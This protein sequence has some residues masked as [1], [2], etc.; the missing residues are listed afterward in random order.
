LDAP[1][2]VRGMRRSGPGTARLLGGLSR[3]FFEYLDP[4]RDGRLR[5]RPRPWPG[6]D[7]HHQRRVPRPPPQTRADSSSPTPRKPSSSCAVVVPSPA[8]SGPRSP[9]RPPP[10]Q[11]S[12]RLGRQRPYTGHSSSSGS[13]YRIFER[14][15]APPLFADVDQRPSKAGRADVDWFHLSL[16]P[17]AADRT[18]PAL[19]GRRIAAA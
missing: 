18:R 19:A 14:S 17:S 1:V 12:H 10:H 7:P 2:D 6:R 3:T 11:R 4:D 13:S 16:S 5:T 9:G 8:R 15:W